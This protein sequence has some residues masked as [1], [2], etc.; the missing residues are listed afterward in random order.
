ML[1]AKEMAQ[2]LIVDDDSVCVMTMQRVIRKLGIP[3]NVSVRSDGQHALDFLRAQVDNVGRLPPFIVMLDLNM[4]RMGGLEFLE[5]IRAD[6]VLARLIVFIFTT[7]DISTD[8]QTAYGRNVA[9]YVIKE[10][11]SE[12]FAAALGMLDGY[13][14][15]VELPA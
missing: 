10:N 8:V 12:T 5:I 13:S 9:G 14:R 6:P 11:P 3:N 4:P 2:F 7:S 1:E 15:I